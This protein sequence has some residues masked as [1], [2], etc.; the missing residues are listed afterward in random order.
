MFWSLQEVV[1]GGIVGRWV[2]GKGRRVGVGRK[3][4]IDYQWGDR[5]RYQMR[6]G[7][8]TCWGVNASLLFLRGIRRGL[9]RTGRDIDKWMLGDLDLFKYD[10]IIRPL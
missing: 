7:G 5:C 6:G 9:S 1:V 8:S 3:V 10:R 4:F 2:D